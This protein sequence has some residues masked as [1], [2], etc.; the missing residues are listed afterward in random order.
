MKNVDF[1]VV[2][3]CLNEEKTLGSC[4]RKAH[5]FFCHT[6]Y[7]YEIIV[8]DNGSSDNSMEVARQCGA[9]VV[10]AKDERRCGV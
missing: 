9:K 5:E 3:P 10:S 2:M 6:T 7:T 4:I 8:A 1:S